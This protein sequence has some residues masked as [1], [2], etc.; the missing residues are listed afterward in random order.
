[1]QND[2]LAKLEKALETLP[3]EQLIHLSKFNFKTEVLDR[4][5]AGENDITENSFVAGA[6]F[7]S[8]R[9][10][11]LHEKLLACVRALEKVSLALGHYE[12]ADRYPQFATELDREISAFVKASRLALSALAKEL[13]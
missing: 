2:L 4:I 3:L 8:I 10:T 5:R 6:R 9:L 13:E 11:P 7:E 1:M 12:A